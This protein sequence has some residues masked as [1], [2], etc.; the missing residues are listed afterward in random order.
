LGAPVAQAL[1][2]CGWRG[3]SDKSDFQA[4]Q[5]DNPLLISMGMP[6]QRHYAL[7]A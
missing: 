1:I 5:S 3:L 4:R 6:E 7:P 2:A